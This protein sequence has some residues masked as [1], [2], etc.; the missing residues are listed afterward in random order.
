MYLSSFRKTIAS[1]RNVLRGLILALVISTAPFSM[2]PAV[3]A[4]TPTFVFPEVI[5][6][7]LSALVDGVTYEAGVGCTIPL[8]VCLTEEAVETELQENGFPDFE[9]PND[10]C[11]GGDDVGPL[12]STTLITNSSSLESTPSEVDGPF[13]V[14]WSVT[15]EDDGT[16]AGTVEVKA[17]GMTKCTDDVGTTSPECSITPTDTGTTTLEVVF[18]SSDD[19]YNGS[20]ASADHLVIETP[21][22][23]PIDTT[24][25]ITNEAALSSPTNVGSAFSVEWTVVPHGTGTTTVTFNGMYPCDSLVA[26]GTCSLTPTTTGW[27]TIVATYFGNEEYN[28]SSTT[29]EHE[30]IP[31]YGCTDESATS[32]DPEATADDQSCEYGSDEGGGGGGGGGSTETTDVCPNIDGIQATVPAG[33]TINSSGN[34]VDVGGGGGGT[35]VFGS[36]PTAPGW[37]VSNPIGEVLGTSTDSGTSYESEVKTCEPLIRD[38]LRMGRDNDPEEV[39][40]LQKFLNEE[41]RIDLPIT[42]FF[43][44]MTF[45]AVSDFQVKYGPQVLVP[46]IPHGLPNGH[47][48]TGYVYKTTKRWINMLHCASLDLPVPQLP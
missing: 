3:Q 37:T 35:P 29:T 19:G 8:S 31:V 21:A 11:D 16:P 7:A 41:L 2:P 42:G 4:S 14:A 44:P 15:L 25:S 22:P 24:T 26:A 17:D 1:H 38:Y 6:L 40:K 45:K 18:T 28:G 5:C 30:I 20:S 23:E 32:Y 46:W 39:K 10:L 43:G 34:C 9:F 12:D 13:I 48:P 47:T 27:I 33:K 36:S